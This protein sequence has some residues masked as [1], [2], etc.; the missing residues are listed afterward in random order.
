M[1]PASLRVALQRVQGALVRCSSL[2][3]PREYIQA[4]C[5]FASPRRANAGAPPTPGL[6]QLPDLHRPEDFQRL[7]VQV[8]DKCQALKN[9]IHTSPRGLQTLQ[10]LDDISNTICSVIDAAELCRNVHP[11]ESYRNAASECFTDLSDF[12]QNLNTE[13]ELYQA[14]RD[15]TENSELMAT[16]TEEQKRMAILLRKE[17][18]RD[19][20]HLSHYER[21]RVIALQNEITRLGMQFQ[22]TMYTAREFIDVPEKVMKS[23]PH[24][25]LAVCE[26]KF[27]QPSVLRVP[28]DIHV[29]NTVMKWVADPDIRKDM[30]IAANTC[31]KENLYVLDEL[32]RKRHELALLLRF[33]TYARFATSDRMIGSP[34][35]VELFIE[36]LSKQL[37]PKARQEV[38]VILKAKQRLEGNSSKE[39]YSWD[40]PYYMGMLKAQTFRIDSRVISSYFPLERCL[41]GLHIICSELFSF[42]L[43]S[44][45]MG[46]SEAWHPDVRKLALTKHGNTLGYIY[47]DLYPRPHKY[48]HAAHFTIRCGK[49]IS[50]NEYQKPIVALVCNFNKPAPNSPSLLT[51]SEVETLFHEFGH[52]M[53]SL[54]SR[55][56]FQHLS[57]TR[58]QLDFVETPS[59]LFE[60]FTWDYR[61]VRE[62][63][64]HYKT[65]EPIPEAMMS[66]LKQSKNM[67]AAM[68]TQTQCLYSLLDL[69]IF[70]KQPLPYE[71]STTTEA[72]KQL[73][74]SAT[75]VPHVDGTFWHLRFGHL[76]GYGAGY[77]SYL[78][79]RVFASDI[80]NSTFA[81]NPLDGAAG[82]ALHQKMMVHGGA[83]D[84]NEMLKDLIGRDPTT[85]S[86]LQELGVL[87][88]Q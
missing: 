77:Y 5:F 48:N 58:A 26:R 79:S 31:A 4:R 9:D 87:E 22:Q 68:D 41:E 12:I 66:N 1:K 85:T 53:H 6:F 32:R 44:L 20:I 51:H 60:Y 17:F 81:H 14:L 15:V 39:I 55:T 33:D 38:K 74:N 61:V 29:M 19:G 3:P 67:F 45:P 54:L 13:V 83:K 35:A 64:R 62:F 49:A 7:A 71:P 8:K 27:T 43:K 59:H 2:G 57:G 50:E 16:F 47:F 56:E 75:L 76:I 42:E 28:T 70:G 10:L 69:K 86:Y 36:S 21:K 46:K 78:Y 65:N 40:V 52:A 84:P 73:Q 11:D 24:G 34:E 72:L 63:A 30:Y 82:K 23:L 37:M 80:W 18:E 25:I 88:Q